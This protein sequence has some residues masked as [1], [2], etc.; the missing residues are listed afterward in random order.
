MARL[1]SGT[2]VPVRTR[3]GMV[4]VDQALALPPGSLH[5]GRKLQ[6]KISTPAAITGIRPG[7]GF[8]II[9]DCAG[10]REACFWPAALASGPAQAVSQ[11]T[12]PAARIS[13]FAECPVPLRD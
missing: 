4:V 10:W 12:S 3:P 2:H 1:S 8:L 13:V 7:V 9:C 11:Q 6:T 5:Q